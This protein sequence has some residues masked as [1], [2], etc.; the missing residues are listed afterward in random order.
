MRQSLPT[1][2]KST[3]N[4]SITFEKS[5]VSSAST[6]IVPEDFGNLIMLVVTSNYHKHLHDQSVPENF[7]YRYA[8]LECWNRLAALPVYLSFLNQTVLISWSH[9]RQMWSQQWPG[10]LYIQIYMAATDP[11]YIFIL[12]RSQKADSII[13]TMTIYSVYCIILCQKLAYLCRCYLSFPRFL[14]REILEKL[15]FLSLV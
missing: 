4:T 14:C 6:G 2:F 7:I 12:I 5:T 9:W 3:C 10:T 11:L 1:S 15:R 13:Q 8:D